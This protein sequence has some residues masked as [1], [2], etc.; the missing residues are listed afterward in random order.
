MTQPYNVA[1]LTCSLTCPQ[2]KLLFSFSS[3]GTRSNDSPP[4]QGGRGSWCCDLADLGGSLED[5][6][7]QGWGRGDEKRDLD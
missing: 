1:A 2:T 3:C 5:S 7:S 6:R 4:A